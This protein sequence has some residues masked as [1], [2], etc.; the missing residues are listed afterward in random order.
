[1]SKLRES[2]VVLDRKAFSRLAAAAFDAQL[3]DYSRL[4]A[5]AFNVSKLRESRSCAVLVRKAYITWLSLQKE[6]KRTS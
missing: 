5:A 6:M 4:A 3:C 2:C 1:M